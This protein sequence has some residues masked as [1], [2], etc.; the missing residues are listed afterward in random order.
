MTIPP[1]YLTTLPANATTRSED[2]IALA[3]A[4]SCTVADSRERG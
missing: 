3:T 4:R 2:S 1:L